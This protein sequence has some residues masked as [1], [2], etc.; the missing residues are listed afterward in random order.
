[1]AALSF[2]D[3]SGA[4]QAPKAIVHA[5][6]SSYRT[7]GIKLKKMPRKPRNRLNIA[8]LNRLIEE[9]RGTQGDGGENEDEASRQRQGVTALAPGGPPDVGERE[10]APRCFPAGSSRPEFVVLVLTPTVMTSYFEG[11][12]E[13]DDIWVIHDA[14]VNH[15]TTLAAWRRDKGTAENGSSTEPT[16]GTP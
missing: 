12:H 6:A 5:R 10:D 4:S 11:V 13:G 16:S 7:A 1:M 15:V 9:G 14:V 3:H 2:R 8:S